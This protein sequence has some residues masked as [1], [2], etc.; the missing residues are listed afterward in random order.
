MR[1]RGVFDE[2]FKRMAVE[3]SEAKGGARSNFG[4]Y[5]RA[6]AYLTCPRITGLCEHH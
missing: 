6:V 4:E 2:S 1:K 5:W 3:L